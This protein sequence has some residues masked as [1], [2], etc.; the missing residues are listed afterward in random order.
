V[1]TFTSAPEM[2]EGKILLYEIPPTIRFG[3]S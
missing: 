2:I 3:H 1:V